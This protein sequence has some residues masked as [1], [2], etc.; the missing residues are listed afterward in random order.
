MYVDPDW[1]LDFKKELYKSFVGYLGKLEY[2][3]DIDD[4]MEYLLSCDNAIAH[5]K[6]NT[7]I[8][9]RGA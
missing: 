4:T 2:G 8:L 1:L 6:E 3:L 5:I 9:K 7:P